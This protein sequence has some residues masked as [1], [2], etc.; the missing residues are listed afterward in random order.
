MLKLRNAEY[1]DID[2]L[3]EWVNDAVVRMNSFSAAQISYE[4]HKKWLE[5]KLSSKKSKLFIGVDENK[6]VGIIRFDLINSED[7]QAS[8]TIAPSMRGK[9]YGKELVSLG[10]EE[11]KKTGFARRLLAQTKPENLPSQFIFINNGFKRTITENDMSQFLFVFAV[12]DGQ[13]LP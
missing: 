12:H 3:F 8:I 1:S 10:I 13:R 11:V 2:I 9:G 6:P 7:A 5:N 4:D